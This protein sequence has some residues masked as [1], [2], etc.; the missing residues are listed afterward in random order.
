MRKERKDNPEQLVKSL[1]RGMQEKKAHDIVIMDLRKIQSSMADY[2]VICHGTSNTQVEAIA[3]S[4]EESTWKDLSDRPSHVEGTR[5]AQWILMDYFNTV[6]HIF[7]PETRLFYE[8][9]DLWS[10]AA[11][12]EYTDI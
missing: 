11:I 3:R 10:D 7:Y 1:V 9:E 4:V 8:I 2:F 6:V 5:N 12:T